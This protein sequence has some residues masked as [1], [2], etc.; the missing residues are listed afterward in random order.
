MLGPGVIIAE[1][2]TEHSAL[3][4]AAAKMEA[5]DVRNYPLDLSGV[6]IFPVDGDGT[7]PILGEFF[8]ALGLITYGFY[9]KKVRNASEQAKL[10]EAFNHP[11]ETQY[12]GIEMLLTTETPVERQW[13][14]LSDLRQTGEQ[15]NVGIP[16][17][18]PAETQVRE[19]TLRVLKSNKGNGYA[20]R[21]LES[22]DVEELPQTITT[23][24]HSVYAAFPEPSQVQKEAL[25]EA[26]GDCGL[27]DDEDERSAMETTPKA[28]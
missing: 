28:L 20:A 3:T 11:C 26:I 6:S 10:L 24:L 27:P 25:G 17:D 16:T 2:I 19:L 13:E 18:R 21:L 7:L 15:G 22:C 9:D 23:F 5:A 12:S 1:G 14:F 8:K 4:T